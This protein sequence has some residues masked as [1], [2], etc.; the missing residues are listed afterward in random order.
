[1]TVTFGQFSFSTWSHSNHD[2]R[3]SKWLLS[4]LETL[5]L[6]HFSPEKKK[7]QDKISNSDLTLDFLSKVKGYDIKRLCLIFPTSPCFLLLP[8]LLLLVFFFKYQNKSLKMPFTKW[9]RKE[10]SLFMFVMFVHFGSSG[11]N[12]HFKFQEFFSLLFTFSLSLSLP[13]SLPNFTNLSENFIVLLY[14][15]VIE[16]I[17]LPNLPSNW[18]LNSLFFLPLTEFQPAQ[19]NIKFFSSLNAFSLFFFSFH[20]PHTVKKR[21]LTKKSLRIKRNNKQR[22]LLP[23]TGK[24]ER[25]KKNNNN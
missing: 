10:Q 14:F 25:N 3:L 9:E 18:F 24:L 20:C 13:L 8:P 15:V 4:T 16:H 2:V 7:N 22:I 11:M 21:S 1:M 5:L 6:H 17:F 19:V 12:F 23:Q